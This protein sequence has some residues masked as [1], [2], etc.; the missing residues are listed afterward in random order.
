MLV[1]YQPG[2]ADGQVVAARADT[3]VFSEISYP[4][5]RTYVDGQELSPEIFQDTF[6]AV[7]VQPGQHVIRFEYAPLTFRIGLAISLTTFAL[8]GFGITFRRALG[9]WRGGPSGLPAGPGP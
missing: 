6:Q 1:S 3:L 8:L 7:Q 4:G 5:W 2:R 9:R